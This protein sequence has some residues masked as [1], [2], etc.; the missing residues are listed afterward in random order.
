[1]GQRN[2]LLSLR[3][4]HVL[5]RLVRLGLWVMRVTQVMHGVNQWFVVLFQLAHDVLQHVGPDRIET[6]MDMEHV[7]S[8]VI[9]RDPLRVQH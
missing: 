7:K 4:E 9:P 2:E 6:E 5:L 1:M 8:A 3:D